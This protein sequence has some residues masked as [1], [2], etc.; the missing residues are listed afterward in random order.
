MRPSRS[1]TT[2]YATSILLVCAGVAGLIGAISPLTVIAA[3]QEA[4][5]SFEVASVKQNKSDAPPYSNF[6]LNTGDPYVENGG[7]FVATNWP[8]VTYVFFAYKL[9]GNQGRSLLSQLPSWATTDHFDIE[10]RAT[11]NPTKDQMRSMMQSLLAERFK[12]GLH[13]EKR[14][15]PV[16]AFVLAKAGKTGPQLQPHAAATACQPNAVPAPGDHIPST[17]QQIV[18]GDMPGLCNV[19]LGL[20]PR[21]PGRSRLAGRNVTIGYMADMFSQRVDRGRPMIDATGLAGKFDFDL[22]F[23]PEA[24]AGVAAGVNAAPESEGPT[25]EEALNDQLGIRVE[26]TKSLTDVLVLDHVERP[27]EN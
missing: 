25:F 13:T 19:I 7:H 12:L 10:A 6:P 16:L 1:E 23:V 24:P 20:P 21:V 2:A 9:M 14:E 22:E 4:R 5:P 17:F 18:S 26:S 15:T 8:L 11:G 3:P 27:T